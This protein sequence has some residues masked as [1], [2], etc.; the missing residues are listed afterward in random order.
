MK[1]LRGYFKGENDYFIDGYRVSNEIADG[2]LYIYKKMS[3][4]DYFVKRID[5]PD[6]WRKYL[7]EAQEVNNEVELKF[8]EYIIENL[9]L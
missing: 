6:F 9:G 8:E 4:Y 1:K 2:E 7:L 5:M 3:F